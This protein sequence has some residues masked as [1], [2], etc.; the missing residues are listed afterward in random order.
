M[1]RGLAFEA[2]NE[3]L[4]AVV[5]GVDPSPSDV[6]LAV[7][8]SGDQ[9]FALLEHAGR[10]IVVDDHPGQLMWIE[11]RLGALKDGDLSLF[12][13]SSEEETSPLGITDSEVRDGYFL[14]PGRFDRIKT[15][16][17][18]LTV[19]P[20]MDM[21]E[22]L[23]GDFN[24]SVDAVFLS[25][26]V[27]YGQ[28]PGVFVERDQ[29]MLDVLGASLTTGARVYVTNGDEVVGKS[30]TYTLPREFRVDGLRTSKAIALE[31]ESPLFESYGWRPKVFGINK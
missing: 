2:T 23:R 12:L 11:D 9:A 31:E 25:N 28:D 3:S 16:A 14:E 7:G 20:P 18:N 15:R 6:V 26:V 1:V 30:R 22:F 5:A 29:G 27:G 4:D 21:L 13:Y 10:V 8:G 17:G 19:L 24:T